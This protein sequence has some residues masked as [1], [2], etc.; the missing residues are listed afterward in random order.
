MEVR[1]K[2]EERKIQGPIYLHPLSK[3]AHIVSVQSGFLLFLTRVRLL[4]ILRIFCT[5]YVSFIM[6]TDSISV[7][8]TVTI[9]TDLWYTTQVHRSF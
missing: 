5:K 8:P 6:Q 7:P 3:H 9:C 4:D 2:S 1:N